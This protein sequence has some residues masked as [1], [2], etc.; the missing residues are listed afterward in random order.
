M[1]GVTGKRVGKEKALN[2]K[3]KKNKREL[4]EQIKN[5]LS[6]EEYIK[7]NKKAAKG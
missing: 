5:P 2:V 4:F 6:E 1:V 3:F 7:Q